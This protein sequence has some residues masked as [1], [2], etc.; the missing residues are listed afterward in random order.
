MTDT[1]GPG[2]RLLPSGPPSSVSTARD[3]Q[4]G[5]AVGRYQ[6]DAGLPVLFALDNDGLDRWAAAKARASDAI[7]TNGGTI[8]HHHGVGTAHRDRYAREVGPL[9]VDLL[10]AVKSTVDPTGIL[11]PGV[12]LP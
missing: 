4:R 12:L 10:R 5:G 3:G 8:S 7:L 11:N 9:G 6:A 2:E 1:Q